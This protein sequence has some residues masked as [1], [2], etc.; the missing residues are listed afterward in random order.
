MI[1]LPDNSLMRYPRGAGLL[2]HP[3]SLPGPFGIG[4]LGP[5]AYRFI[6]FLA[7]SGQKY[8]QILPLGPTGFG[9]SPYQSFSAFAGNP[10]LV[11]PDAL[12][13]DEL[14]PGDRLSECPEFSADRVD[15][16]A[17]HTWKSDILSTAFDNFERSGPPEEFSRFCHE[18]AFW[19]DDYALYRALKAELQKPW[20]EWPEPLRMREEVPLEAAADRLSRDVMAHKFYQFVFYDQWFAVKKYANDKGI[21]LIGDIPIFVALDSVDVWCN[22][23]KFKLKPDGT[24]RVVAG[25]P[26]DYFSE[27]GQR[28]GNPL[29]DWDAMATDGFSWWTARVEFALRAVDIAR[30]D[31]FIG[32]VRHWEVPADDETA[33]NGQWVPGPGGRLFASMISD[34]G[35]LPLIAEDLGLLTA[36]VEGLRDEFGFPGMRILQYAFG[37]DAANRDLP[38]NYVP[39]TVAY[40]GT[41]DNDTLVGWFGTTGKKVRGHCRRYLRF[42]RE[43]V[44]WAMIRGVLSSVADIAVV[45]VQDVLGL[46]SEAR[47]NTPATESGNWQWRLSGPDLTSLTAA[48]LKRLTDLYGRGT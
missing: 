23:D 41:H 4:D 37:G 45:P 31:H 6:D 16:G 32:F 24:P 19:L 26:P 18:N 20:Y 2:L 46:G 11:S 13:R 15:Y 7:E 48:K 30:L 36:E 47:M 39:E 38:H 3:T 43:D 5:E 34:L 42:Q 28:W 27:T 33:E 14:L 40:T 35:P 12:L 25:V 44:H 17:V 21:Y 9:D 29:Y 8:W 1:A 10:L 22:Q